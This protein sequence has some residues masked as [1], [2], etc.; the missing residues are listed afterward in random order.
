ME[1]WIKK[2]YIVLILFVISNYSNAQYERGFRILKGN[3]VSFSFNSIDDI[4]NGITLNNWTE[5]EVYFY[6]DPTPANRWKLT[7]EALSLNAEGINAANIIPLS[8]IEIE[9]F[10]ATA[11]PDVGW[12]ALTGSFGSPIEIIANGNNDNSGAQSVSISYRI[13]DATGYNTD[14]YSLNLRF[15]ILEWP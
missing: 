4:Q 7:V 12:Q 11:T 2:L 14:I 9:V 1:V 8:A 10:C 5:L 15:V 6:D 3:S 13:T